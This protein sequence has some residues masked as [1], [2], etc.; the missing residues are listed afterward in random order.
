M[1]LVREKERECEGD[2]VILNQF[3]FVNFLSKE[4]SVD[5]QPKAKNSFFLSYLNFF[6]LFP[7]YFSLFWFLCDSKLTLTSFIF[8]QKVSVIAR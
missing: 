4:Q 8:F 7:A 1:V 3:V 5:E 6:F 2:F